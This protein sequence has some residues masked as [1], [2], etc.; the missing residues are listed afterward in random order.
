MQ[1]KGSSK[2]DLKF[3]II[4]FN[5]NIIKNRAYNRYGILRIAAS[6]EIAFLYNK[7]IAKPTE[8][9]FANCD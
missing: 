5:W 4:V 3:K 6:I 7:V 8:I 9:G 1:H 2:G